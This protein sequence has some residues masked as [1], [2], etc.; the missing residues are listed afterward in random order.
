M[1]NWK[2]AARAFRKEAAQATRDWAELSERVIKLT[3][4]NERLRAALT[5]IAGCNDGGG[6]M[7]GVA[8]KAL[9]S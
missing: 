9:E 4:E 8:R 5:K 1:T 6:Y 7:P 2:S 3:N